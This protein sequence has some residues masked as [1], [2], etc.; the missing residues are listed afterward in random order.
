MV[1]L[2]DAPYIDAD[3]VQS[4]LRF[5]CI[6]SFPDFEETGASILSD[7]IFE[8]ADRQ[9]VD[10]IGR[11]SK[12]SREFQISV[13][14]NAVS[15]R[16]L[17]LLQ[18]IE[19]HTA[20]QSE[21]TAA[22]RV[23]EREF[24]RRYRRIAAAEHGSLKPPD[25]E[26]RRL[27]PIHDLYVAPNVTEN[28]VPPART[29]SIW[30]FGCCVDRFVLLGDPGGGKSTAVS[31]LIN[32]M[33]QEESARV[34]FLVVPSEYARADPP[35]GS[36]L[37]YIEVRLRVHYQCAPPVGLVE[38]L[39]LA[40]K[41]IVFFDGL[42]G[43]VDGRRRG[44]VS[45]L[46]E[47]FCLHYPQTPV[48]VTSRRI[49]YEQAQLDPLQFSVFQLADFSASQSEE[50][51][52]KWFRQEWELGGQE[53]D[54]WS[55]S[56]I[57]ESESI[58]DL[59]SN[60]LMLALLCILYRGEGSLPRNRPSVYERCSMLLFAEWDSNGSVNVDLRARDL[61]EPILQYL[62]N[63]LFTKG[64][65]TWIVTEDQLVSE[66]RDYL[67]GHHYEQTSE[68]IRVAR[69]FVTFCKGRAWVF[70]EVGKTGDGQPLFAFSHRTFLE[71]FTASYLA[72]ICDT[73]EQLAEKLAPHIARA[74]W[75]V[76]AQ[77]A[78]QIMNRVTENGGA[79]FYDALLARSMTEVDRVRNIL[80]FSARCLDF[81]DLPPK[82]IRVLANK[83]LQRFLADP[84]CPEDVVP[85]G[86][87]MFCKNKNVR[88]VVA[89][90]VSSDLKGM[91]GAPHSGGY[92]SALHLVLAMH[93]P[94]WY[95]Q[96][97]PESGTIR[98]IELAKYW[99]EVSDSLAIDLRH[100]IV[101]AAQRDKSVWYSAYHR[102]WVSAS[103]FEC[104][105]EVLVAVL[106][107]GDV[108]T[109]IAD[110]RWENSPAFSLARA[111]VGGRKRYGEVQ[112]SELEEIVNIIEYMGNPPW[113]SDVLIGAESPFADLMAVAE[114]EAGGDQIRNLSLKAWTGAAL[115]VALL[116]E[117]RLS[118][119]S[120]RLESWCEYLGCLS[121]FGPY[122]R[123]RGRTGS[124][125]FLKPLHFYGEFESLMYDW[126]CAR[127]DF[128]ARPSIR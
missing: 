64:D 116:F 83:S 111:F 30:E 56:F 6:D 15:G 21:S 93:I 26:K 8:A 100:L 39:L 50:Y 63:W 70:S 69:E 124:S 86:W 84:S 46:V 51:A 1:R 58:P 35:E 31:V 87:L 97:M 67:L 128:I 92:K 59:R 28:A 32:K 77:L 96:R 122:L 115:L 24:L 38:R 114:D 47:N 20:S 36:V 102:G 101:A 81:I 16:C 120:T 121:W 80:S 41:A 18:A 23:A 71:Y 33:A 94:V 95:C 125:E 106:F 9:M 73:P 78:I 119:G 107:A 13:R 53:P 68:A 82:I 7:A 34:P 91:L 55:T 88:D 27:V 76:V 105:P 99:G 61:I 65:L 22:I 19:R 98:H 37:D 113:I 52:T 127:I 66:T 60:P 109:G 11:L 126:A 54:A 57:A 3:R 110:S 10:L 42:D 40:G 44:E 79:R 104:S 45:Q 43:L 85:L 89:Y 12:A 75:D 29:L 48:L 118:Y 117:A 112:A 25:F 74:E 2:T 14:D 90:Q 103:D 49:G 17:V 4:N 123:H 108:P 5:S 62:A 72:S